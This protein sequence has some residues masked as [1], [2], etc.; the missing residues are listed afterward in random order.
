M[1]RMT[2]LTFVLLAAGAAG[3]QT[4]TRVCETLET[5]IAQSP[6][7]LEGRILNEALFEAAAL[8]CPETAL[9][10]LERDRKSTR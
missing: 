2:T 8:D 5:R 4:V 7:N 9:S 3:A 10:L 1:I 6:A